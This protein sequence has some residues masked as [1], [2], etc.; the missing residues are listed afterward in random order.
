M[1][2]KDFIAEAAKIVFNGMV[3]YLEPKDLKNEFITREVAH[4]CVAAAKVLADE[5]EADFKNEKADGGL[6]R[7]SENETFFDN[8]VCWT[9]TK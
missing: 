3:G 1:I 4:D 8:Y 9:K 5:L 7:Y 6:K 2:Y